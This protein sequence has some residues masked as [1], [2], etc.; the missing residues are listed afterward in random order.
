MSNKQQDLKNKIKGRGNNPA[1]TFLSK[2]GM[3]MMLII[4]L[5]ITLMIRMK[6]RS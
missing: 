5:I 4:T 3:L 2:L 1:A 6:L